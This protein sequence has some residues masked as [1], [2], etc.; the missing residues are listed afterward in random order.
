MLMNKAR[1]CLLRAAVGFG[2]SLE[3]KKTIYITFIRSI[4]EQSAVVWGSSLLVQNAFD[5]ER[6][7]KNSLRLID[8]QYMEYEKSLKKFNLLK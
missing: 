6:C 1:M 8:S 7:Q 3:D 2:A 4:L 5:L